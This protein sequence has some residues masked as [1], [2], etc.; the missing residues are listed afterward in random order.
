[1]NFIQG[2]EDRWGMEERKR[3]TMCMTVT[4]LLT[5]VIPLLGKFCDAF[6]K[7][8]KDTFKTRASQQYVAIFVVKGREILYSE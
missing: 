4:V 3:E 1:M 8:S 2:Q 7:Q 6:W 5:A